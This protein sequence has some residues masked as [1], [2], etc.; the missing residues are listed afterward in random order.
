MKKIT[1]TKK[2]MFALRLKG[3]PLIEI[4]RRAN[5][6]RERVRQIIGNTGFIRKLAERVCQQCGKRE[7]TIPSLARRTYCSMKCV[8]EMRKTRP[9]FRGK[10]KKE[11]TKKDWKAY[12]HWQYMNTRERRSAW[13]RAYYL[14]NRERMLQKFR[15]YARR[16][17]ENGGKPLTRMKYSARV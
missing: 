16:R 6:S 7:V 8:Y 1:L 17:R 12:R 15:D 13:S 2:Q 11:F 14:R 9:I 4:G 3:L 5:V 10:S